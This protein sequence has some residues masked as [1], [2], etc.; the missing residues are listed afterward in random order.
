[1]FGARLVPRRWEYMSVAIV[2]HENAGHGTA[3]A[4]KLETFSL[5]HHSHFLVHRLGASQYPPALNQG[6][7]YH[8]R[9]CV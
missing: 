4:T 3:R 7:P 8:G 9:I 2:P 6:N 1:M 5:L